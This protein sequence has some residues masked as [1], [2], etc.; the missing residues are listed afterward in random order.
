MTDKQKIKTIM[1]EFDFEKVH[2]VMEKLDWK[3]YHKDTSEYIIPTLY[4]IKRTALYLLRELIK[5]SGTTSMSTGGFY[6]I[7]NGSETDENDIELLFCI[8]HYGSCLY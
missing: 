3:W 4:T 6:A 2:N 8:E 1:D 5:D 7:K